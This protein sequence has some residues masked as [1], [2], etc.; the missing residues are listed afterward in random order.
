MWLCFYCK[1]PDTEIELLV[2]LIGWRYVEHTLN[3][4]PLTKEEQ[5]EYRLEKELYGANKDITVC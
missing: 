5:Y 3:T 1:P 2:D 4:K